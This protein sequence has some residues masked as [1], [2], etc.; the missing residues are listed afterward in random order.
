M[1]QSLHEVFE[2]AAIQQ[3]SIEV[4]RV[5][6]ILVDD[7]GAVSAA[8]GGSLRCL[9]EQFSVICPRRWQ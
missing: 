9:L 2:L 3:F 7:F 6:V 4:V 1:N 8:L 5:K